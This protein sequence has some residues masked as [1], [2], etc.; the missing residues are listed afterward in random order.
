MAKTR[1]TL[2]DKQ[3]RFVEEYCTDFN[4]TQAAIRA[5]Y[6]QKTAHSIGHENLSKPEIKAA[7]ASRLDELSMTAEEATKRLTDWGRA[8]FGPFTRITADGEVLVDLSTAEAQANLHLVK[9]LKVSEVRLSDELVNVK[10]EIELHDAKDATIQMAKIRGKFVEKH[11]HSGPNG[12]PIE[13]RDL[14][15][16]EIRKRRQQLSNRL[17]ATSNGTNGT[18]GNGKH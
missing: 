12:G 5:G 6:S 10:T 16:D 1:G 18:N 8:S 9:K 17:L 3:Q 14:S 2:T 13:T 15:D 4:A 7:L 11:E